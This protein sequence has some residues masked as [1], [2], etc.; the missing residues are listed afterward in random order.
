MIVGLTD[1]LE[2]VEENPEGLELQLYVSPVTDAAPIEALPPLQIDWLRPA[3][4]FGDGFTVIV[5]LLDF[6]QPV[7]DVSVKVYVVVAV[8]LT[9]GFDDVEEKPDGFDAQLYVLPFTDAAPIVALLPEHIDWLVPALAPGNGLT[10]ITTLL[11]FEHPEDV[12]FSV[13]V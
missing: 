8:G 6:E 10:V 13:K 5:M 9:D 11:V 4:A 1:A 2:A 12:I 7:A 3:F